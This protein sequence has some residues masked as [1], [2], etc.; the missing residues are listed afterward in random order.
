M[1]S[2][3]KVQQEGSS[4]L[5]S[6]PE[7]PVETLQSRDNEAEISHDSNY[8]VKHMFQTWCFL[9]RI[10][11]QQPTLTLTPMHALDVCVY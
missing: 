8:V 4:A 11:I 2:A 6:S 10:Y 7:P 9:L 3:Y 1:K 5:S